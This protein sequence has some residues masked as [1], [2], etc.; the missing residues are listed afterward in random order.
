MNNLPFKSGGGSRRDPS[1]TSYLSGGLIP[2]IITAVLALILVVTY[3]FG[4]P[5]GFGARPA[6]T[7]TPILTAASPTSAAVALANTPTAGA[8]TAE[9]SPL[10]TTAAAPTQIPTATSTMVAAAA[11]A[12]VA[13]SSPAATSAAAC[14]VQPVRGFG[15][16][17]TTVPQVATNLGCAAGP[18]AGISLSVQAYANGRTIVA[19]DQKVT[20][21]LQSNGTWTKQTG[22][23]ALSSAAAAALGAP[24]GSVQNVGG[25]VEN[26]QHGLLLW[27][28]DRVIYALFAD[29]TW[30]QHDDTFVDATATPAPASP[31]AQVA[32]AAT[33]ASASATPLPS[34][35]TPAPSPASVVASCPV[36]PVRGFALIYTNQT[37]VATRLGCA[38]G[39]EIGFS[40]PL[41]TFERGLMVERLDTRQIFVIQ[42]NGSWS[43]YGDSYS[44]GQ[45]LSAVGTPPANLSAPTGGFGLV[46]RQQSGVRQNLGWATGPVQNL[47]GA[48]Q[49]FAGGQML[50]TSEKKIYVLYADKT[51]ANYPDQ[52][53]DPSSG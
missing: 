30:S 36:Q 14:E 49:G 34:G 3:A 7:A 35:P 32:T 42:S 31:T 44:N 26:F 11:S 28:P 53:V 50:W 43:I 33:A 6:A 1:W 45:V 37:G 2:S 48:W 19:P 41:Q 51:G 18:E 22:S 9:P 13:P 40:A 46:W 15:L 20:Y 27:T 39:H 52:F 23:P 17:Y 12:T 24:A 21:V 16:L 38:S 5:F 10:V 8:P 4:H 25:A 47:S 29:G